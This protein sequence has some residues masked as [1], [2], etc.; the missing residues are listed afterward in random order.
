MKIYSYRNFEVNKNSKTFLQ[1]NNPLRKQEDF[2][3]KDVLWY[4]LED[5]TNNKFFFQ[6]FSFCLLTLGLF[7]GFYLVSQNSDLNVYSSNLNQTEVRALTNFNKTVRSNQHFNLTE[8][9]TITQ[10]KQEES[11]VEDKT[12]PKTITYTVKEGDNLYSIAM[13]YGVNFVDIAEDNN[14]TRPF[15]LQVGQQLYINLP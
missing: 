4:F 5:K 11:L 14:L 1:R 10:N 12:E 9:S 13:S 7:L 2:F 8:I 6:V 15:T 3:L